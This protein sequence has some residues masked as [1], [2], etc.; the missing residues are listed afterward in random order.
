MENIKG[1]HFLLLGKCG[2]SQL[3]V[4]PL[5]PISCPHIYLQQTTFPPTKNPSSAEYIG[6][7]ALK[8][9]SVTL[10]LPHWRICFICEPASSPTQ[11]HQETAGYTNRSLVLAEMSRLS[12]TV[13]SG[14]WFGNR[15]KKSRRHTDSPSFK[16][17]QYSE[18]E[19]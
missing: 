11:Y 12:S 9:P 6:I 7:K 3:H 15:S 1:A 10:F 19:I 5:G 14:L 17:W 4:R 18:S 2:K 16:G 13:I 8:T